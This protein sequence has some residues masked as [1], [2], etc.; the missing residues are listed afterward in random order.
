MVLSS[1]EIFQDIYNILFFIYLKKVGY[2][3]TWWRFRGDIIYNTAFW[4]FKIRFPSPS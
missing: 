4:K 3:K 2:N 1:L